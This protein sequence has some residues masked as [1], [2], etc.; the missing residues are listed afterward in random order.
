M[1]RH[2]R[3]DGLMWSIAEARPLRV[4]S[5]GA[6]GMDELERIKAGR[7]TK[8]MSFD[9]RVWALTARIPAGSVVTYRD[10]AH[11][12]DTRAYRAVGQA[13]NR[14]PHAPAV[15]CHRVVSATGHLNGYARGLTAK[16]KQLR[17]EGVAVSQD[18]VDLAR[19]RC[20]LR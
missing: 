19:Y 2:H 18:R 20:A 3:V 12:L 7:I 14:N 1:L 8:G 16:A 15:P 4:T 6:D 9:Q 11:R 13:L 5:K 17:A 10:I